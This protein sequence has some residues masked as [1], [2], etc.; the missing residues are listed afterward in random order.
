MCY[1]NQNYA[2]SVLKGFA[3]CSIDKK[4]RKVSRYF[5]YRD[6]KQYRGIRDT[7]IVKI[8]YR[9]ISK[10]RQ[11]RPALDWAL[12]CFGL[13]WQ[14]SARTHGGMVRLSWPDCDGARRV[15]CVGRRS[16]ITETTS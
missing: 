15:G 6:T 12:L 4:Y 16:V 2:N 10:Y 11:Y 7:S 3:T 8:W 9:D 5:W 13:L 14:T 1:T